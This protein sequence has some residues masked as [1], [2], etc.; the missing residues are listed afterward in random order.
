M[1]MLYQCRMQDE[2]GWNRVQWIPGIKSKLGATI[3]LPVGRIGPRDYTV[4]HVYHPPL[5]EDVFK[6]HQAKANK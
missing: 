3:T 2:S 1:S 4:I 5:H 6:T